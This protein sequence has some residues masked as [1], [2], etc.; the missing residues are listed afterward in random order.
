MASLWLSFGGMGLFMAGRMGGSWL[1]SF[2]RPEHVLSLCGLGAA[3]AMALGFVMPLV[4]FVFILIYSVG[5]GHSFF[6][7]HKRK[8]GTKKEKLP[9]TVPSLKK[10]GLSG[11]K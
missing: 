9:A 11:T 3:V 8:N 2:L 1:M 5:Y 4:C 10:G 6:C 7:P